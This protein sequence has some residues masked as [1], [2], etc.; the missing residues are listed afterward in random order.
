MP[1][2]VL[3]AMPTRYDTLKPKFIRAREDRYAKDI[4]Q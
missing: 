2:A 4:M 1:S 3:H